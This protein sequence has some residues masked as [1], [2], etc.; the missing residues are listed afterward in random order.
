VFVF[1]NA[2]FYALV[3]HCTSLCRMTLGRVSSTLKSD[4]VMLKEVKNG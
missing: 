4:T 1:A 2:F 3:G